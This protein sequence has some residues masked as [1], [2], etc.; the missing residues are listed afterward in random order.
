MVSQ[1]RLIGTLIQDLTQQLAAGEL[2]PMIAGFVELIGDARPE[3]LE[4]LEAEIAGQRSRE[5]K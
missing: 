2:E 1:S 3:L 5:R 4:R